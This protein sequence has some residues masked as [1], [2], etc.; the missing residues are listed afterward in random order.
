MAEMFITTHD[1][2]SHVASLMFSRRAPRVPRLWYLETEGAAER[3]G[4]LP[5]AG[6][7][8][9]IDALDRSFPGRVTQKVN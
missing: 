1:A 9:A 2:V 3:A 5:G 8:E 4:L 7:D 6:L